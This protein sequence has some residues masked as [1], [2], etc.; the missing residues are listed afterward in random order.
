MLIVGKRVEH[1]KKVAGLA[2]QRLAEVKKAREAAEE[3]ARALQQRICQ[4]DDEKE[5]L[6]ANEARARHQVG[7]GNSIRPYVR[8]SHKNPSAQTQV[9]GNE[10]EVKSTL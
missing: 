1:D 3:A 4:A 9:M 5:S 7:V 2:D 8:T 10:Y 6:M